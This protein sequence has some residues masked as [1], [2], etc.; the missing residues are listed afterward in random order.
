[1]R[2]FHFYLTLLLSTFAIARAED[3]RP[4]ALVYRGPAACQGCPEAV[5]SLLRSS[6]PGFDVEYAG[7]REKAD[8]DAESLRNFD[9][10]A[11]PGGGGKFKFDSYIIANFDE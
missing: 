9:L 11:Q 8:V 2:A 6:T 7:P 3:P 5:A 10:Y 1:M 4:K